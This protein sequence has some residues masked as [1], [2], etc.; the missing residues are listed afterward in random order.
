MALTPI[1]GCDEASNYARVKCVFVC[2]EDLGREKGRLED[3]HGL[4]YQVF[5]WSSIVC[6]LFTSCLSVFLYKIKFCYHKKNV[7]FR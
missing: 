6:Y 3:I 2:G 4:K 7:C 5:V 1:H